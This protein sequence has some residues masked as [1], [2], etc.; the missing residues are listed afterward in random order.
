M[1][2]E[3]KSGLAGV[4]AGLIRPT[5]PRPEPKPE[6]VEAPVVSEEEQGGATLPIEEARPARATRAKR[7]AATSSRAAAG[8]NRLYLSEDTMFRLR[9]TAF[10]KGVSL[11]EVAEELLARNLPKWSVERVG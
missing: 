6:P 4:P 9:M 10:K 2:N 5:T 7:K 1:A 8:G 11:S 3:K